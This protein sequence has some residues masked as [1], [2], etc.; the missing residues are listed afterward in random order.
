MNGHHQKLPGRQLGTCQC[1]IQNMEDLENSSDHREPIQRDTLFLKYQ[2]SN[3]MAGRHARSQTTTKKIQNSAPNSNSIINLIGQSWI[4]ALW[5]G[6]FHSDEK[7]GRGQPQSMT[8]TRFRTCWESRQRPGVRVSS[9]ALLGWI[10]K[11]FTKNGAM[12]GAR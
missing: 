6:A 12:L 11:N 3:P 8:L 1:K 10:L 2:T 7:S 9:R 4:R 5:R